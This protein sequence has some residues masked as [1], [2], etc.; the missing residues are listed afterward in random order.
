MTAAVATA[1]SE[2]ALARAVPGTA[3]ARVLAPVAE[4]SRLMAADGRPIAGLRVAGAAGRTAGVRRM[5]DR[6]RAGI[7]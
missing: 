2:P 6:P 5:H 7:D 1:R 4:A 3:A